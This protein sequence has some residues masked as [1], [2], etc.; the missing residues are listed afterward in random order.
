[1]VFYI[2]IYIF[3]GSE[4]ST[5][6]LVTDSKH[7]ICAASLALGAMQVLPKLEAQ[8]VTKLKKKK[9]CWRT[10]FST[11]VL[12]QDVDVLLVLEVVIEVH[13][14]FMVQYS[15]QLNLSVNLAG[16]RDNKK[17]GH[18]LYL[19]AGFGREDGQSG[20]QRRGCALT[21]SRW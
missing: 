12:Q 21:F 7:C 18:K 19:K 13:N 3:A 15:V 20:A 1:M 8:A 17:I 9:S 14:V 4:Q 2:Y 10:Y 11:A 5:L 6:I 16:G